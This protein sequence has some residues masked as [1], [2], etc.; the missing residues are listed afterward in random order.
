MRIALAF[1]AGSWLLRTRL[2]CFVRIAADSDGDLQGKVAGGI[3]TFSIIRTSNVQALYGKRGI[4]RTIP[5]LQSLNSRKLTALSPSRITS[6]ASSRHFR[7]SQW[8]YG[9]GHSNSSFHLSPNNEAIDNRN[10]SLKI[11]NM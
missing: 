10:A 4:Q 7:H 9:N 6:L 3:E 8:Y 11:R 2:P 5:P 1:Y